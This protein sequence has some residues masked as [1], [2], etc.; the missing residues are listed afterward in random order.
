MSFHRLGNDAA[1][2]SE[3]GQAISLGQSGFNTGFDKW[4]W[5]EWAIYHLLFREAEAMMPPV[6]VPTSSSATAQ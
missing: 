3:L 2:R 6:L 1:A 5:R 4:N